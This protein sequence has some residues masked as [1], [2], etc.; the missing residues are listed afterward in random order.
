[1]LRSALAAACFLALVQQAPGAKLP[2]RLKPGAAV[3]EFTVKTPEGKDRTLASLRDDRRPKILVVVFWSHTSPW[4]RAW[5]AELSKIARDYDTKNV[6]IV[7]IDPNDPNNRDAEGDS[8]SARD[9]A[10]YAK[11]KSLGFDVCLDPEQRVADLFG[12]Q[13][14]PDVF[15]IGVDGKIAYTGRV[16]D[17]QNPAKPLDFKKSFLRGALD[18][19][20]ANKMV[21]DATTPPA[22]FG[23]RRPKK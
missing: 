23:I 8:D 18:S 20:V 2:V 4:S 3:P 17:M 22:G 15:V 19:L 1:M 6:R 21:L 11:E 12:A 14:T 5:D 16:N 7:A 9:V 13:T 10:R